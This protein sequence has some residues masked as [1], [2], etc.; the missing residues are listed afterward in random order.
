SDGELPALLDGADRFD[1]V[2]TEAL[3]DDEGEQDEGDVADHRLVGPALA[4]AQPGGLLGVAEDRLHAP[5]AL[6]ADHDGGQVRRKVA[7]DEVV[8]VAVTVC[9]DD[10]HHTTRGEG[11]KPRTGPTPA[12]ARAP[13]PSRSLPA[14]SATCCRRPCQ[15]TV[16][17]GWSVPTQV[18]CNRPPSRVNQPAV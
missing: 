6:L 8:V 17:R 1:R 3:Q 13:Q 10:Q 18:A 7:S 2:D 5:A 14:S 4:G 12:P 11:E 16:V 9:G 15:T